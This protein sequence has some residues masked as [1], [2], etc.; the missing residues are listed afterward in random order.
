MGAVVCI[1][2]HKY[3]SNSDSSSFNRIKRSS[4][5]VAVLCY[6]NVQTKESECIRKEIQ[7]SF[8]VTNFVLRNAALSTSRLKS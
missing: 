2:K 5:Y 7:L 1:S 3:T 8:Y 4:P 6:R